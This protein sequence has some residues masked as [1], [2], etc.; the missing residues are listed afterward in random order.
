MIAE[1][2]ITRVKLSGT[3]RQRTIG[4]I[5]FGRQ[6]CGSSKQ[7]AVVQRNRIFKG[8]GCQLRLVHIPFQVK[9]IARGGG[10]TYS[11]CRFT[12]FERLGG[13]GDRIQIKHKTVGCKI[14]RLI[15]KLSVA[16]ETVFGKVHMLVEPPFV[17]EHGIGSLR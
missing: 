7:G 14:G 5:T 6:V 15:V 9:H 11:R 2:K 10:E 4:S 1:V 13:G 8:A 12:H 16:I 17:A 3:K